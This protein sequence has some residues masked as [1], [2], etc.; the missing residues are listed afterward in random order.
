[1]KKILG[2]RAQ[3]QHTFLAPAKVEFEDPQGDKCQHRGQ[4]LPAPLGSLEL[5]PGVRYRTAPPN[6]P[7][8]GLGGGNRRRSLC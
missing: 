6:G 3:G 1:M 5:G 4:R 2:P 7:R 8:V